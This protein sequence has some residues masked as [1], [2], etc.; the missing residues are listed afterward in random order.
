MTESNKLT[1]RF[2]KEDGKT[3]SYTINKVKPT[4]SESNANLLGRDFIIY[5]VFSEQ[6]IGSKVTQVD[7]INHINTVVKE[8]NLTSF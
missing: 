8:F 7:S 2:K 6:I 5:Q 4:V 3:L 1:F